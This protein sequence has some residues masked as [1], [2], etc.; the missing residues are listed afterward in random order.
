MLTTG[1]SEKDDL[2][3]YFVNR[4]LDIYKCPIPE[5]VF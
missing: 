2:D 3:S 1:F 5:K 4:K